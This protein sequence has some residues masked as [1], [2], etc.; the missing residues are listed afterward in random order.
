MS[1]Q[2]NFSDP[3]F[4]QIALC[5]LNTDAD[6]E[7]TLTAIL[8]LQKVGNLVGFDRSLWAKFSSGFV[9]PQ[10]YDMNLRI[11]ELT[12]FIAGDGLEEQL[13]SVKDLQFSIDIISLSTPNLS[14]DLAPVSFV[15]EDFIDGRYLAVAVAKAD[16]LAYVS[17][18]KM[19]ST[20]NKVQLYLTEEIY[21]LEEI[22]SNNKSKIQRGQ[23]FY[24][25]SVEKLEELPELLNDI[26][27][28][29]L[30]QN[31]TGIRC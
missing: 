6:L 16:L 18:T 15:E 7:S 26:E 1:A 28:V 4:N 31:I 10:L 13:N 3:L 23:Y 2:T 11:S 19:I 14:G 21:Q 12:F 9:P 27:R 24:L 5:Q 25:P 29:H 20:D 8:G 30:S 17:G 22:L